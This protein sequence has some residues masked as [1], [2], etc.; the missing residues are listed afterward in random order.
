MATTRVGRIRQAACRA[1][2]GEDRL[3]LHLLDFIGPLF[4]DAKHLVKFG[5]KEVQSRQDTAVGA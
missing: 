1:S 2:Q 3:K 4:K 5:R